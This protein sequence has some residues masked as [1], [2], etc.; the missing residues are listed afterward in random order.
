MR[1]HFSKRNSV[2]FVTLVGGAYQ[3]TA[4]PNVELLE[5]PSRI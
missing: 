2:I 3:A 5:Y 1:D 4:P